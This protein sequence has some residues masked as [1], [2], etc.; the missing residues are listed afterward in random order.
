MLRLIAAVLCLLV[1][2]AH[3][4]DKPCSD[5][6]QYRYSVQLNGEDYSFLPDKVLKAA[7]PIFS[8]S[9]AGKVQM[10]MVLKRKEALV[11]QIEMDV[12]NPKPL[13]GSLTSAE[14]GTVFTLELQPL[15]VPT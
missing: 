13:R 7:L 2:G 1:H 6:Y 15:C 10:T 11:A 3:A 5:E 14:T 12:R 8:R 4:Q 9:S